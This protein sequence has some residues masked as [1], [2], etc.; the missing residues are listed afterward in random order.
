MP[1]PQPG[2][3]RSTFEHPIQ[4]FLWGDYSVTPGETVS[5]VVRPVRGRPAAPEHGTPV[6]ITVRAASESNGEQNVYFNRGAIPSQAFA[7]RFGNVGPNDDEIV[8]P[9]NEKVRWLSRGLLQGALDYIAQANG[10]RFELRVAAYEFHYAPILA[11]LRE[12]AGT[13]AQVRISFD[14][15]DQKRDGTIAETA[16]SRS[17][18]AAIT[19]AHLDT[20]GN[21]HLRP[22]TL[23]SS[24]PHNKFIVLLENGHP[25]Q[26]WTGSTNFSSSGFLGQ[27]N[28]GHVVRLPA[29]A[30]RFNT[31]WEA[32]AE[33]PGTRA[34]KPRVMEISPSPPAAG[35]DDGITTIFSPRRAGMM[36]WYAERFG[37]AQ[38]SVM[39]TAAFGVAPQI[40][41]KLAVDRDFLRFIL[42]ERRDSNVTEQEMVE[43]DRDTI[44]ALGSGLNRNTIR[45]G[46][47]GHRLDQW[48]KEE[49]HF[50]TRGHI[51]YIH[52]KYLL[53]DALGEDPLIF[54][55][56]ANFSDNSVESN[57]ENM[58][59]LR[60]APAKQVAETYVAEFSRLFNHLHFRT[61]AVRRARE[62]RS[63]GNA[64]PIALLDPTD[65]WVASHFRPGTYRD[66]RRRLFA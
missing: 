37:A 26:V 55:G 27:S 46:L 2:E 41:E 54:T 1:D 19:A 35:P 30:A 31:Y 66:R 7:D 61:I 38:S 36:E 57:D 23:Y 3:R 14:G 18:F 65:G 40:A 63:R 8:D 28:V 34:F 29:V 22:R 51:F 39:F 20:A 5:Y 4:S 59:L 24:I 16:A 25:V 9:S 58:L 32:L 44:V 53:L 52:T 45:F 43:S 13:G 10:P 60:G 15:G 49:E 11:A 56:S 12:A 47:P 62:Q 48:F 6:E 42:M 50:R 33:D 64:R 21:V 17:N